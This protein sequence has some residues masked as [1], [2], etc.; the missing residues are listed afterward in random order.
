LWTTPA[1]LTRLELEIAGAAAGQSRLLGRDLAGQMLTPQVPGGMGLGI[2]IDT[3]AGYLRFG[4]T[5]GNVGY[6][7]FSFAWPATDAAVAV[8][9]NSEGASE[10]LGSILA[11]ADG[12]HAPPPDPATPPRPMT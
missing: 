12:R 7:C 6:G 3:S 4:H 11:A 8:M 5:G 9:A 10:V 1:D 2:E